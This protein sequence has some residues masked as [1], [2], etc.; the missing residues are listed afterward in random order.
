[1]VNFW[2]VS[3]LEEFTEA[4]NWYICTKTPNQDRMIGKWGFIESGFHSGTHFGL[5]EK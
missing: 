4:P 5:L 1:M 2:T 3:Y